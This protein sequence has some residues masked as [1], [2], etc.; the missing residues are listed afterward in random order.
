M[1]KLTTFIFAI[2]FGMIA[3]A[4]SSLNLHG[5]THLTQSLETNPAFLPDSR[6]TFG[7]GTSSFKFGLSSVASVNDIFGSQ[8][9]PNESL[10]LVLSN[11][12]TNNQVALSSQVT[13][14]VMG[15]RF[16]ENKFLTVG[17]N[18]HFQT[19]LALPANL[20]SML[21]FGN[22]DY[23][24]QRVG[25]DAIEFNLNTYSEAYVGVSFPVGDKLRVGIKGQYLLGHANASTLKSSG[26]IETDSS[27]TITVNSDITFQTSNVPI[28]SATR[29]NFD[30]SSAAYG[31]NRGTAISFGLTYE[32]NENVTLNA[33]LID[34]GSITWKDEV[35]DYE[36]IGNY[37][38]EPFDPQ[39]DSS[40]YTDQIVDTLKAVFLPQKVERGAY[41][42]KIFPATYLGATYLTAW[43]H[44][45]GGRA[46]LRF[47]E[48]ST[49]YAVG[50]NYK[51]GLGRWFYVNPSYAA[52]NGDFVNFGMG[53]GIRALGLDVYFL[54]DNL[55]DALAY[56]DSKTMNFQFGLQFTFK[57][58]KPQAIQPV[59]F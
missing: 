19:N 25:L 57:P 37:E 13:P 41:K 52:I 28:D 1:R 56:Y 50:V 42:S 51:A 11:L 18:S 35:A 44:E 46:Y 58:K 26:Y 10:E 29:S 8:L 14:F 33:S 27:Y 31:N 5:L 49:Y 12:Q 2:G 15:V 48:E 40:N 55:E 17:L 43:G 59:E 9:S 34:I 4:Q 45:V 20:L 21:Y 3:N 6:F 24:G 54:T 53:V 7:V 30:Y 23:I 16:G 22:A 47:F 36:V 32:L 38:L 39:G